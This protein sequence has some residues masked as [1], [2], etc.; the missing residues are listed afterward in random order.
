MEKNK[1]HTFSPSN[2]LCLTFLKP[3]AVH[4]WSHAPFDWLE[5]H[6]SVCVSAKRRWFS[7]ARTSAPLQTR[8]HL[9]NLWSINIFLGIDDN[10]DIFI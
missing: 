10:N 9:W 5:F 7:W 1:K 6:V 8:V 3:L 2:T 4:V